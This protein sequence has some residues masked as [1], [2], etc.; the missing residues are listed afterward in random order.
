MSFCGVKALRALRANVVW[1]NLKAAVEVNA[2]DAL[3][4]AFYSDDVQLQTAAAEVLGSL[5]GR[6]YGPHWHVHWLTLFQQVLQPDRIALIRQAFERSQVSPSEDD[7]KYTLQ[8]KLSELLSVLADAIAQ[9]TAD[10]LPAIDAPAFFDLLLIVLQSKS[11]VVSIPILHSWTKLMNCPHADLGAQVFRSLAAVLQI[12]STRLLR[13]ETI[14]D[15]EDSDDEIAQYLNEDFDTIPER[16]AFLGNYRRY[17]VTVIQN[18]SR[19]RP[20]E[21]LTHVLGEMRQMLEMGP[22]SAAKGF[23]AAKY[24]K[25][26]LPTLQ[27]DAQFQV[28]TNALKG[29]NSWLADAASLSPESDDHSKTEKE[30]DAMMD[31]LQQWSHGV[32]GLS[33]DDPEAAGQVLQT[34][35]MILRS[36]QPGAGFVLQVVQHLLTIRLPDY[37]SLDV[38]S[39]S[40][41]AFDS[42]RVLELQRVAYTFPNELLE[43]YQDLDSRINELEREHSDDSRVFWGY[44]A[45]LFL[46][47]HRAS[48][49]DQEARITRLQQMLKPIYHAWTDESLSASL[50]NFQMF[51]ESIGMGG[52]AEFYKVYR[53]AEVSDWASQQLDEAGQARQAEIRARG[54]QLPLRMTKSMLAATTEKL[55]SDSDEFEVACQLWSGIIPVVLPKL[56][57]MVS[58]AQAFHNLASWSQLPE[59]LQMVVKRTLQDRFWQSGISNESKDEFYARISGS[60]TS[61]E[62]F[63]SVVRGTTRHIRD[64]VYQIL[65][66]M[67]KFE[68]QFYGLS[69]LA[70]SLAE[71]LFK[72]ADSLTAN[73]LH[74]VVNLTTSL[75]QRCPPHHRSHFLPP[76]LTQ[77]FTKLDS[78]ISTE[79]EAIAHANNQNAE[80]DEL[81][82]EMRAESVLRHLT[83]SMVSFVTFL[84]DFDSSTRGHQEANGN[85]ATKPSLKDLVLS[86][87]RVL[88]PLILFCTHALRM[89]DTR[90]C[91]AIC[92]VFR[93]IIPLFQ[94]QTTPAEQ[95]REFISTEVLK[96]CITSLNEPYFAD[97]Q[98]DLA[99]LIAQVISLYSGGSNTPRNVL[100]SLPNMSTGK[101]EHAIHKIRHTNNERQQRSLVLELLEGV[102]GVSIHEAGKIVQ[103]KAS[104]T[105][106]QGVPLQYMEVE[107]K[108][109]IANGDDSGL[110][111]I[112]GL[113]EG[114]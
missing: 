17:C 46:V 42:L 34:L 37:P 18:T 70:P 36:Y 47:V 30:R 45:F 3:F 105:T 106:K 88:E 53:F 1:V 91:T 110:D 90:C 95:V 40:A 41:K 43:V 79:W 57:Q 51:C 86:E 15:S 71:A 108:K 55:K 14:A 26:D 23:D 29:Y 114:T 9:H 50:Q 2:V 75:V 44:R 31:F 99:A 22:Y 78:K 77:I 35:V 80:D 48:N 89:R 104:T 83:Y 76:L 11:L 87:P 111:G 65:Y 92:R 64:Q 96:A 102:R 27:F 101:V 52:L 19:S 20:L 63:A 13:Y 32:I 28:V 49:I 72:D 5:L 74:S 58:H 97:M 33:I 62:G 61:Y 100:L 113:F 82:E 25:T 67:T 73:H 12:C 7:G 6:P 38:Y 56:L 66:F 94:S 81:S 21:A 85:G 8:K 54:D 16:H 69:D 39:E 103:K 24:S 59:E 84:L 93:N 112:S 10:L 60:K 109:V 68:E 107:Q 98:K 4:L